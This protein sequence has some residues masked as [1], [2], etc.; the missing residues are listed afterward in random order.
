MH[1][2]PSC[3]RLAA[4]SRKPLCLSPLPLSHGTPWLIGR[5]E[6]IDHRICV[7][8]SFQGCHPAR[9][10][11]SAAASHDQL[12]RSQRHEPSDEFRL[13]GDTA[14][15]VRL[16]QGS[17]MICTRILLAPRSKR[18]TATLLSHL[19]DT[20]ECHFELREEGGVAW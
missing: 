7:S 3:C 9:P 12:C 16:R 10:E 11:L 8:Y 4:S 14:C 20:P 1:G 18:K 13:V 5:C 15:W 17:A 6:G 19:T 2:V